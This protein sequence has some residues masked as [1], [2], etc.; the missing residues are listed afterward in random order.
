M[1]R[2]SHQ[3]D[4]LLGA[5]MKM[6]TKIYNPSQEMFSWKAFRKM[7]GKIKESSYDVM[8]CKTY[9]E[10]KDRIGESQ[11]VMVLRVDVDRTPEKMF[12]MARILK[13]YELSATFFYRLH[14]PFYH[15]LWYENVR[16]LMEVDRMGFEVGLHC[17]PMD[18]AYAWDEDPGEAFRRDVK[19]LELLLGHK[20]YGCSSHG[21][22][23]G[24][25]NLDF[26]KSYHPHDFDLLYEAYDERTLGLFNTGR[27]L[28]DSPKL[29]WKV[30]EKGVP[31]P[32]DKRSLQEHIDE[33][34]PIL[35]VLF[36]ACTLRRKHFFEF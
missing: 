16:Y 35:Y 5:Y 6:P 4:L 36:H 34:P 29:H 25:N 18:V 10:N 12:Y 7:L 15:A 26:W 23:S 30:F 19:I 21:D 17:E 33:G 1:V 8:D 14:S 27:Y 3:Y 11:K 13:T 31:K 22:R 24:L 20:I 28:S 2:V 9:I 32:D